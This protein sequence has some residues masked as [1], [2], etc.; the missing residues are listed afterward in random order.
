MHNNLELLTSTKFNAPLRR[1]AR[2]ISAS[3]SSN[4]HFKATPSIW[5]AARQK[6]QNDQ[7][8]QWRLRFALASAHSDQSSLST[9]TSI[10]SL[11]THQVHSEDSNQMPS[12]Q[13]GQMPCPERCLS[14]AHRS[15]CWFCH[16]LDPYQA[17]NV[18]WLK[19][20]PFRVLNHFNFTYGAFISFPSKRDPTL[21]D[22]CGWWTV[23]RLYIYS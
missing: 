19:T 18:N 17:Q 3:F 14:W 7:C 6:Q 5:A 9:W 4:E 20:Q 1:K 11:G 16:A 21:V 2:W 23:K 8:A 10:G 12:N 15:F 22:N 13:T